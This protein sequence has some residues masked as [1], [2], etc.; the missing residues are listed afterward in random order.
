[1]RALVTATILIALLALDGCRD[2]L[3]G[4]R[5]VT[6]MVLFNPVEGGCWSI[7]TTDGD[8]LEPV[9]L[10]AAFRRDSL[11]VRAWVADRLDLGSYCA[12]GTLVDVLKIERR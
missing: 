4:S 2:P 12:V 6:G 10:A 9:A 11:P 1:M 5:E 7:R 3:E 8:Y